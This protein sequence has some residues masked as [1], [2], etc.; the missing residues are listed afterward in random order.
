MA[1]ETSA[2]P[3]SVVAPTGSPET[4]PAPVAPVQTPTSAPVQVELTV[5]DETLPTASEV[6]TRHVN[7]A[8]ARVVAET[9]TAPAPASEPE[10]TV[11]TELGERV[12]VV[13]RVLEDPRT[14][15]TVREWLRRHA[16]WLTVIA[17]LLGLILF[18]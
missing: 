7:Q 3:A 15:E 14:P 18:T 1:D 5:G 12:V 6:A 8:A 11:L 17:I 4:V 16:G 2:M 13:G 9:M 10:P